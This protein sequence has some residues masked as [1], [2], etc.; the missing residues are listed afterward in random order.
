MTQLS[1]NEPADQAAS[2][3]YAR[4]AVERGIDDLR[5]DD[6]GLVYATGEVRLEVGERVLVPLRGAKKPVG[7]LVIASGGAE[8]LGAVPAGRVKAIAGRTGAKLTPAM[9]ELAQWMSAYY[10]CP[11][12]MVGATMMPAAVKHG[13]GARQREMVRV[14]SGAA[15]LAAGIRLTPTMRKAWEGIERGE[16]ELPE[17]PRIL[18][19]RLGL[20]SVGALNRLVDAGVLERV[21]VEVVRSRAEAPLE[22][23]EGSNSGV[24]TLTEEQRS[25]AEGISEALGGF[26]VHLIRGVTGSGKTE[27]YLRV[28]ARALERGRSGLVLVPEIALTPQT[29]KRFLDRFEAAGV[30]VLHSGLSSA[31]RHRQWA[32]AAR[33]EARVVVGARSAVFAPMRDLG[34]IVVDEEHDHSYK[35]DQLPRY[36]ARDVAIKRG[37]IEGATVVLGSAT[38]SLESWANATGG[39]GK[40]RLWELTK[41]IGTARMPRVT[42]VD[43][44]KLPRVGHGSAGQ[45]MLA[46]SPV[47]REALTRTLRNGHQA[48]LLLNR[49]GYASYVCCPSSTCGW[50]LQCESC[51]A[52]MVLHRGSGLPKGQLVRCHHCLAEQIVPV[53]CPICKRKTISLGLGTQRVEEELAREFGLIPGESLLRVDAD[54]MSTARDY[55]EALGRFSRGEVRVLMGTQMIAKG[56]DFP[57][58]ALV[59]V[60]NADTALH[61]PD[62]RSTERTFQLVSQVA[63]RAGRGN[64]PGEVV[65]QTLA[66]QHPAIVLA[67]RHD[68]LGFARQELAVRKAG[69]LPPASRMARI[70]V[71]DKDADKAMRAAEELVEVLRARKGRGMRV[72]GP[73]VCP[74]S[75]VADFY[76]VAVEVIAS[77]PKEIQG[78]LAGLRSEKKLVSDARTAID[79][80][81]MVLM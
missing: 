32:R 66:P 49:R 65:V 33:G 73:L 23:G 81:P 52:S 21:Q 58:V 57:N 51:D 6:Q 63:G 47:L 34:V 62:F 18:A 77:T 43:L 50:R 3:W 28:L 61:L 10:V 24:P 79:V 16:V 35:Q 42:I 2:R 9:V 1:F 30:A 45:V 4:V 12:G 36:N 31:E 80:D 17:E 56:L 38:P 54:T 25:A 74:L 11:L 67:S 68:Y 22:R 46:V 48:I 41:R 76:R 64:V 7:G 44:G 78:L 19:A 29:S 55:F 26:G 60:I 13:V 14:A 15:E 53:V 40:F 37:Q 70:V 71:R 20:A 27:V 39:R 75:R 5:E 69:G 8:V 72:L 59:G